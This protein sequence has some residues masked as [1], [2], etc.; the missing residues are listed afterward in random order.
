MQKPYGKKIYEKKIYV[1]DLDE[2]LWDREKLY[3]DVYDIIRK[4]RSD[5]HK[6]FIASYN[7]EAPR[8]LEYFGIHKFFHG[9]A[10]QRGRSKFDMICEIMKYTGQ[11]NNIEFFDD[12]PE[13]IEE[14]SKKSN[15][16]V[17]AVLVNG[18]LQ[19]KNIE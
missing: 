11:I 16:L 4:L 18:G 1:F 12:R 14:V 9:G 13:N 3:P 8:V 5:G 15:G 10:Y 7:M 6:I 19:W 2:T 17:K